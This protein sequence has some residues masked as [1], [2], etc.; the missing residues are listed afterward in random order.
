M[1]FTANCSIINVQQLESAFFGAVTLVAAL[2]FLKGKKKEIMKKCDYCEKEYD[3]SFFG[4]LDNGSEACY[5]CIE[6][7]ERRVEAR[8]E[9]LKERKG[10]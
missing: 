3:D 6:E 2:F 8:I 5:N 4:S 9:Q 10:K 1:T 7:E